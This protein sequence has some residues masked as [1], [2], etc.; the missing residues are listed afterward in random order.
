MKAT[1]CS[2]GM[3]P[4]LLLFVLGPLPVFSPHLMRAKRIG[5]HEYG[6]LASR[7]VSLFDLKWVRGGAETRSH[8][9]ISEGNSARI[10]CR[11][12][13]WIGASIGGRA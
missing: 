5:L 9:G 8:R 6:V 3:S 10:E 1:G 2:K 11:H 13:R 7:Y 12:G 4:I